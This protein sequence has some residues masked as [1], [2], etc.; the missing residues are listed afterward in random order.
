MLI[1]SVGDFDRL[2]VQ[3]IDDTLKYCLGKANANIIYDYLEK[4]DCP[5]CEVPSKPEKFSEELRNI[6]GFGTK[7]MLGAPSILE[8]TILES[9]SKRLEISIRLE[10]P[11]NFPMQ[12]R[13]LRKAYEI[14]GARI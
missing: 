1:Q 14:I 6:M 2:A 3:V 13:K 7:Q 11:P 5:L 12:I 8:E 10:K 9:L 4:K